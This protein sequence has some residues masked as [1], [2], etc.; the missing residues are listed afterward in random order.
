[1][2]AAN[3]W[4]ARGEV[5]AILIWAAPAQHRLVI[6]GGEPLLQGRRWRG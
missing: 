5:A 3:Q 2:T 1:L 4:P 6:T